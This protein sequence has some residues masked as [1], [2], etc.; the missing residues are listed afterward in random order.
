MDSSLRDKV[1]R[2]LGCKEETLLDTYLGLPLTTKEVS[3]QYLN[4]LVEHFY[5]MLEGCKGI[6][7]SSMGKLQLLSTSLQ[8]IPVYF[9]SSFKL[10]G[11]YRDIL[12]KIQ[13]IFSKLVILEVLNTRML[14]NMNKA[15]LIK[16]SCRSMNSLGSWCNI[17]KAK[18]LGD[19][20]FHYFLWIHSYLECLFSCHFA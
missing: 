6:I 2:I 11:R 8:G 19:D 14:G 18:Y 4:G 3:N 16:V 13:T 12:G 10:L 1:T 9:L 20:L 7:L 17:V 15:L 5:R